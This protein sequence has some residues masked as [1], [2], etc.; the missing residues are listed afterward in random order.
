MISDELSNN[1]RTSAPARGERVLIVGNH[2]VDLG[3][4]LAAAGF[5]RQNRGRRARHQPLRPRPHARAAVPRRG[6]PA[7]AGRC[8]FPSPPQRRPR[9]TGAQR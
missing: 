5:E 2:D 7:R 9:G 4:E 3:A 1:P 6:T 8:G